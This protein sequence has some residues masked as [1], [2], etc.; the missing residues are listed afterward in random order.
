MKQHGLNKKRIR[1]EG[2]S[3]V[4][5]VIIGIFLFG[6]LMYTLLKTGQSGQTN[7]SKHNDKILAQ[8]IVDT[9][10][11]ID[12]AVQELRRKGCAESQISQQRDWNNNGTITDDATDR[13]N[14][15]AP[16]DKSCHLF[17]AAGAGLSYAKLGTY[18]YS[19]AYNRIENIGCNTSNVACPD[20]VLVIKF[21]DQNLCHTINYLLDQN[22]SGTMY[23]D[24]NGIDGFPVYDGTIAGA[25][26]I[27]GNDDTNLASRR[28][29]CYLDNTANPQGHIF[30]YTLI[31]R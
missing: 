30:Y 1:T 25:G 3:A 4:V 15:N 12:N 23:F 22:Y 9:A 13:Y 14:A 20:I 29:A 6:A 24:A 8:R 17:D 2:G 27:I 7:F 11:Y 10:K 16:T 21:V 31:D 18:D 5:Y 19:I 28:T 26:N